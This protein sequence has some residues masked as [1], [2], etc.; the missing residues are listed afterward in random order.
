MVRKVVILAWSIAIGTLFSACGKRSAYS[1][2]AG[3]QSIADGS[4]AVDVFF[5]YPTIIDT[6]VEYVAIDDA[7]M[8]REASKLIGNHRGI[9]DDVANFYAPYYRQLSIPY[10]QSM[11]DLARVDSAM[12]AVAAYDC[13][14]AF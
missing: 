14:A 1:D 11:G 4:K 10:I 9:F 2:S 3:W 6:N 5:I 12:D 7:T 8:R 13:Y